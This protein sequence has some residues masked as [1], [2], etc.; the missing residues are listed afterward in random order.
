[1]W[2]GGQLWAGQLWWMDEFEYLKNWLL[3]FKVNL[4]FVIDFFQDYNNWDSLSP[5]FSYFTI[6]PTSA[7]FFYLKRV[8]WIFVEGKNSTLQMTKVSLHCKNE[9]ATQQISAK[10]GPDSRFVVEAN[11]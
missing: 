10:R 9:T 7:A 1:M 3:Q 4:E 6:N 2:G 8:K 5:W 11:T